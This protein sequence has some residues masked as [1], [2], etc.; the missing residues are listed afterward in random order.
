MFAARRPALPGYF[1]AMHVQPREGRLFETADLRSTDAAVI[2]EAAANQYFSGH[3]LGHALRIG[4]APAVRDLQIVG[5]VPNIN[6]GGPLSTPEA[7]VYLL[8]DPRSTWPRSAMSLVVR[9]RPGANV[10]FGQFTHLAQSLGT[11]VLVGS[12]RPMTDFVSEL[13]VLPRHRMVLLGMLG[14][15]GLLLA[16][17]GIFSMTAYAVARRTR[18]IGVR[19]A[20]GAS[21]PSVVATV[22]RDA[23]GPVAI[24]L[25]LG[26]TGTYYAT[27]VLTSSLF[28]TPAHD[29]ATLAAVVVVLGVAGGVA[30]WLPARRAATIDPVQALRAE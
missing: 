14:G 19:M 1:E 11:P 30:A 13:V 10:P 22:L 17:A 18:E 2:N 9:L 8:P 24:G 27:R 4:T 6:L 21:A 5:V 16:L 23:I 20:F 28:Q 3:A 29:P 12:L 15:V 7:E 25:A 26:L